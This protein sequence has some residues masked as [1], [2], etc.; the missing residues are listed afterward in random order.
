M[1]KLYEEMVEDGVAPEQA[2]F[3]LPQGVQVSWI[4]TGSL[5]AFARFVRQRTDGHAQAEIATLAR[6]VD[7]IL[8]PIYPISWEALS[9]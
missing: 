4:W 2:R 9:R 8:R 6:E 7:E 1:I 5:A 3:C